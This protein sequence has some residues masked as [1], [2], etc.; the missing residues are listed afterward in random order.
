M[1]YNFDEL[2]NRRNTGSYKWD[3][4][5]NELPMWVA[6]MDFKTAPEIIEALGRRVE[7]GIY[8]YEIIPDEWYDAY[9]NW[10]DKK[11]SFRMEKEWLM[12][13]TGVIPAIS[14]TVRKLTTPAENVVIMTPVYNIFF[15][16]IINNGR[17]VLQSELHY[18]DGRYSIDFEDLEEKLANPQTALLLLCNPQNPGG[19]IW[20]R[21]ELMLIGELAKKHGVVVLSDEIHCE[22]TDPGLEYVPF[23]SASD[24]CR[25]ISITCIAPTK[26][27]NMAGIQTAAICVP[28]PLLRHKVWRQINTDEVAEPNSFAVTATIAAYTKGEEWLSELRQYIYDNKM[29]ARKFIE[30]E[31]GEVT[32][33]S[34]NATYLLWVDVRKITESSTELAEFIREKTGLYVSAGEVFGADGYR[35]LRINVACPK[36]VLQDG[37]CRLKKGIDGYKSKK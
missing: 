36:E 22:F 19:N 29:S 7:H 26:T 25:D 35:F 10:W 32:V 24:I 21:E 11:H 37:L 17:N 16:S 18:E 30:K 31:I 9:I 1:K 8:G 3:V 28:N 4:A 6:D 20:T 12:F 23:A 14:S 15:N 34:S 5:E 27:F 2:Y 33:V 13:V